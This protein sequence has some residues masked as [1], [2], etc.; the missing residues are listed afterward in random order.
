MSKVEILY[1][2]CKND[3]GEVEV[4]SCLWVDTRDKERVTKQF[5]DSGYEVQYRTPTKEELDAR[6]AQL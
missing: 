1:A 6:R 2:Q 4:T 5:Q 3:K